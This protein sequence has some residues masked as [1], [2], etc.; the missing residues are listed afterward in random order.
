M[1]ATDAPT[2]DVVVPVHNEAASLEGSIRRLDAFLA[3]E[4]P[5]T[6]RITV[7]DNASADATWSIA[8]RLRETMPRVE[9]M[10]LDEKGRGRALRAAWM[11]SDAPVV[12][13][14]DVDLSTDLR[15]LLPLVAPLI[16]GHSDL[17]IGSRLLHGSSVARGARRELISR[18]YNLLLRT[19]LHARF[20]D[21]QCGFKAMRTEVAH[22]LLP[23]VRDEAWFFDT[24]LLVL[25]ERAGLRIHEVPVDWTDDPD[26]RVHITSTA[27]QDLRGMVRVARSLVTGRV[28]DGLE[29]LE[30][31][32]LLGGRPL[33]RHQRRRRH[34]LRPH[35]DA[36]R[37]TAHA[38]RAALRPATARWPGAERRRLL[39]CAHQPPQARWRR[40]RGRCRRCRRCSTD[41]APPTGAGGGTGRPGS[42][43]PKRSRPR[44]A[45]A[46]RR[47]RRP[48]T[49]LPQWPTR[50]RW[51]HWD[52]RAASASPSCWPSS[53]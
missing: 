24:E 23:R 27:Y 50:R 48:T 52:A 4:F 53:P 26:S 18:S 46:S 42:P 39:A 16:S 30:R 13:Y 6:A 32:Q 33:Q 45:P 34:R 25:A 11:A 41:P 8:R 35:R 15:A 28:L 14:V 31:N 17:A 2:L 40:R 36:V 7:V 10:H 19:T 5:F 20:R 9:A 12:A 37:L 22:R 3:A 1:R 38:D 47:R 44:S 51:A 43:F 49:R 21:A 29:D